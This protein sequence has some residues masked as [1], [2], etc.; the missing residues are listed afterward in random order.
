[1]RLKVFEEGSSE[2]PKQYHGAT[3]DEILEANPE[4]RE[5]AS[6]NELQEKIEAQ[7][8]IKQAEKLFRNRGVQIVPGL[9]GGNVMTF[10]SSNGVTVREDANGATVTITEKDENGDTV[11]KEYK[12]ESLDEI[13]RNH[14]EIADRIPQGPGSV[15]R[16]S[17]RRPRGVVT[18]RP[19]VTSL[20][21]KVRPLDEA[22]SVHLGLEPRQGAL[23]VGVV[24]GSQA[25]EIGLERHDVILRV[26]DVPI[27][28]VRALQRMFAEAAAAR[29]A[30][31]IDLIRRGETK[32][33]SR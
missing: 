15:L 24:P 13:R 19:P 9:G 22:L 20:G 4:L 11:V 16:F 26:N 1:V 12:G 28:D 32:T 7:D 33:L 14:P 5:H 3:L 27:A 18:P 31:V 29:T 25:A 23:V 30:L 6:M 17:P 21:A 10:F 8:P 2:A